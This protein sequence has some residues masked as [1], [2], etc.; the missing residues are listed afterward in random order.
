MEWFMWLVKKRL[1][2]TWADFVKVAAKRFDQSTFASDE[3][4]LKELK[5]KGK[6]AKYQAEFER[7]SCR[8]RSWPE[9]TLVMMYLGG[10]RHDIRIEVQSHRPHSIL[11]YFELEAMRAYC[12]FQ[13]TG[14]RPNPRPAQIQA[15]PVDNKGKTQE[16]LITL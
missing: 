6:V 3:I 4:K 15:A 5:Q 14:G 10:L 9:S 2:L 8:I 11:D 1:A 13:P 12:P 16:P 7:L